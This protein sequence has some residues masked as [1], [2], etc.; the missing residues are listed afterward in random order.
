MPNTFD[1][2]FWLNPP[3]EFSVEADRIRF[4]TA[5]GT[6]FWQR[7]YYGF[8]N[9]NAHAFIFSTDQNQ[10][11]YRVL[12]GYAPKK[13][14]DQAGIFLGIDSENW[15]KASIEVEDAHTARLG[16]VVTNFGFSDWASVDVPNAPEVQ[17]Y[18]RLSRRGKDFLLE[19]S[20]DGKAYQQMRMFHLHQ[21]VGE[22]KLGIYACSPTQSSFE[23]EFSQIAFG[24]CLWK[25][26]Q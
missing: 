26:Y 21:A 20:P 13:L 8:Q 23:V 16:S 7:T 9:D 22:V 11:T 12:A 3:E 18:Y 6:D 15:C 19:T 14:Y 4:R 10:F 5:P 1:T 2:Y 24:E 25:P 17:Q